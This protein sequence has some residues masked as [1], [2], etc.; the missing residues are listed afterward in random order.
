MT[1][2]EYIIP[3]DY[4]DMTGINND[5][6]AHYCDVPDRKGIA[7]EMYDNFQDIGTD[8]ERD[9]ERID[10]AE[11]LNALREPESADN[12]DPPYDRSE[13]DQ[14]IEQFDPDG[15]APIITYNGNE[16]IGENLNDID[17]DSSEPPAL[18]TT[19]DIDVS[20]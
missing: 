16:E 8:L 5:V 20:E 2:G 19:T 13:L 3:N 11:D 4:T 10:E 12:C 1:S 18:D 7:N 14:M 17:P 15:E 9:R 6:P